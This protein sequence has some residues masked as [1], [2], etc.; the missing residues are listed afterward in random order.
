MSRS[1][2]FDK[3]VK[4]RSVPWQGAGG[5]KYLKSE[6]QDKIF[7]PKKQANVGSCA[8]YSNL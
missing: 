3:T 7:L 4:Y 8:G 6:A 5:E 2:R 1:H